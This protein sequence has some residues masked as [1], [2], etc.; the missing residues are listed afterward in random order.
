M[1]IGRHRFP[2]VKGCSVR[3]TCLMNKMLAHCSVIYVARPQECDST[4]HIKWEAELF[5]RSPFMLFDKA[6]VASN[7][8]SKKFVLCSKKCM[9]E[10]RTGIREAVEKLVSFWE[11]ICQFGDCFL[12][13]LFDKPGEFFG[14][15]RREIE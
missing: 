3:A 10:N 4:R 7:L 8:Y 6:V 13:P 5:M 1:I 15:L 2:V 14:E 12:L 9:E 11:E